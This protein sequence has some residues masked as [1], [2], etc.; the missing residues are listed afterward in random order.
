MK[1][2]Y[3]ASQLHHDTRGIHETD[4]GQTGLS[5]DSIPDHRVQIPDFM[6]VAEPE[7]MAG[8]EIDLAAKT[9]KV[10]RGANS[11]KEPLLPLSASLTRHESVVSVPSASV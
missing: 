10:H 6:I 4:H 1:T 8:T 11:V 7:A 3:K 2:T 9:A 5:D